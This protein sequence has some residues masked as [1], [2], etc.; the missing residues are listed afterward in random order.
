[1]T[2]INIGIDPSLIKSKML[3]AEAREIKRIPNTIKSGKA[4]I[5]DIPETFRMWVGHV[6]FFYNKLGYLL[7]RY[8]EIKAECTRRWYNLT[9]Y[10]GAWDGI[11]S[12]LMNDYIPTIADI[13]IITQRLQER[14]AFN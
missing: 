1:M 7:K 11:P 5:K 13:K 3:L 4:V 12:N 14:N 6:K 9:D 8:N 2:R 10:S